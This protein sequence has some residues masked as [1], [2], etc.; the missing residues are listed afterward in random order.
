MS[1][2][3]VLVDHP[4]ER[5]ARTGRLFVATTS[6]LAAAVLVLA[7]YGRTWSWSGFQGNENVWEWLQLLAQPIA[8]ITLLVQLVSPLEAKRWLLVFGV[9]MT[10]LAVLMVGGYAAHWQWTGFGEY[11]M[12]DWLHLLVLPVM[13]ALLPLWLRAGDDLSRGVRLAMVTFVGT[14][15]VVVVA[16]YAFGWQW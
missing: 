7:T 10:A 2:L 15:A 9:F 4:D 13:L 3:R 5:V 12:W 14:L 16:G 11:R 8:I 1:V 6:V